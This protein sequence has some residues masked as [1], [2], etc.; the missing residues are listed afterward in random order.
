MLEIGMSLDEII[1]KKKTT[2]GT[3]NGKGRYVNIRIHIVGAIV[4]I[5]DKNVA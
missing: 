5:M 4:T 1:Q 2:T 3:R